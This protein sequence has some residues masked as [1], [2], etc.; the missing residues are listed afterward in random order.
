MRANK[1][2]EIK[3]RLEKKE[4]IQK[5]LLSLGWEVEKVNFQREHRITDTNNTLG[6]RGIFPRVRKDGDKTIFTV[7]VNPEG[8][9]DENDKNRKYFSRLEYDVEVEDADKM[10]DILAILGLTE[11]RILEKYRQAWM[12]SSGKNSLSI[13]I[14]SLNF[15]DYMELEGKEDDIEDMI[16]SLRLEKEERI[17]LAYWRVYRKYCEKNNLKEEKNILL[18]EGVN[19]EKSIY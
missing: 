6:E 11:Q 14:D 9:V 10:V 7:K 8:K 13:V 2:V 16:N 3:I 17:T 1:E 15:G 12:D 5:K 18:K 19:D 4:E